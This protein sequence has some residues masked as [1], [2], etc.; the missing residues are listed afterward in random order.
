M[1]LSDSRREVQELLDAF[2]D[3]S[4]DEAE[5]REKR[6]T[7]YIEEDAPV[8]EVFREKTLEDIIEEQRARLAAEGRVG[9]PVTEESFRTWRSLKLAQRQ[10]E[11]EMRFKAEQARKKGGGGKCALCV[12]SLIPWLTCA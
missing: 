3:E 9:T 7:V 11:A 5:D 4:E 6:R 8:V 1:G 12:F 2:S 10:V